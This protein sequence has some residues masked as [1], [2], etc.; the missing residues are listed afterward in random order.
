M[1]TYNNTFSHQTN[2]GF[3]LGSRSEK[4][5]CF[6]KQ[7]LECKFKLKKE[8]VDI[9][10]TNESMKEFGDAFTSS[11]VDPNNNYEVY[12]QYGDSISNTCIVNYVKKRFPQLN[13]PEGVK[14]VARL[15]INYGSK[16]SFSEIARKLGFIDFISATN[17]IKYRQIKKLLE[18]VFEAFI[19]AVTTIIDN[20]K[21]IGV[22]YAVAY[23][24]ISCIFDEMHISLNYS[25]LY[26]A[27]TRLKEL[28]DLY[29]EQLGTLE[30]KEEKIESI[31]WTSIYRKTSDGKC[32]KIGQGSASLKADA[33]QFASNKALQFLNSQGYVKQLSLFYQNIENSD[34]T[35]LS[36]E[37]LFG[38]AEINELRV[39][40]QTCY[41]NKYKITPLSHYC[42]LRDVPNIKKCLSVGAN[43]NVQDSDGMFS[44][45]FVLIGSIEPEIVNTILDLLANSVTTSENELLAVHKNIYDFYFYENSINFNKV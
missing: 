20:H 2:Q 33:H 22:G 1:N 12:E 32:F 27:K 4:F 10:T 42:K 19:G 9:L 16:N 17:D 34:T 7:L 31:N 44:A 3:Y 28:F 35:C 14:I 39:V 13:C 37:Q 40:K 5:I 36:L 29:K 45:D 24:I 30:Y 15:K 23:N 11:S 38:T 26:D 8:Y 21:R 6:I 18:D 25:D 41:Q 43:P